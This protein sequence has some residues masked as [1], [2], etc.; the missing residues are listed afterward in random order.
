MNKIFV[1]SKEKKKVKKIGEDFKKNMPFMRALN[2]LCC[3]I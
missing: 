2:T 3:G 1:L